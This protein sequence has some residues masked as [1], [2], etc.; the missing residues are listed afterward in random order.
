MQEEVTLGGAVERVVREIER[1][2]GF[3]RHVI[4]VVRMPHGE[5]LP[6]PFYAS[7][8]AA[9]MDLI[10]AVDDAVWVAPRERKLIPTGLRLALPPGH[11]LQIR[12]RSG[13]AFKHG[14][15]IPNSPSTID[16]DFRGELLVL[17]LNVSLDGFEV[18]R[19]DRIA[20]AVLAPVVRATWREVP[21][22]PD[23]R[24]GAGGFGSTGVEDKDGKPEKAA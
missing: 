18:K 17:V 15:V 10:A 14:I 13:L 4:D 23:T 6:L 7:D 12:A 24:R 22:L 5:G 11:E 16:E 20:Q 3:S 19:G 9:A 21:G 8:G 2:H 1:E